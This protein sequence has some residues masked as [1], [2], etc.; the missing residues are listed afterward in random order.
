MKST[1][2]LACWP[3]VALVA[4]ATTACLRAGAPTPEPLPGTAEAEAE[5]RLAAGAAALEIG[6]FSAARNDLGWVYTRCPSTD[7]GQTALLLLATGY[8]DPR[9]PERRPD[10]A[11]A[12]AAHVAGLAAER[13][14]LGSAGTSLF[15]LAREHGAPLPDAGTLEEAA[16]EVR[17]AERGCSEGEA[18][19]TLTLLEAAASARDT[20]ATDGPAEGFM[21]DL[22]GPSVPDRIAAVTSERDSLATRVAE[23]EDQVRALTERVAIQQQELERIRRTLRP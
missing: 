20:T 2:T 10:L 7:D 8:L 14:V 22:K 6:N 17:R 5:G 3:R 19:A 16:R 9:N 18:R 11:A 13:S 23:L 21:P 15:V 12:M 1:A 4:V